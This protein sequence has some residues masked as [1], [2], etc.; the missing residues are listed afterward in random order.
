LNQSLKARVIDLALRGGDGGMLL[1]R[2][3]LRVY[4][5]SIKASV[6]INLITLM[7]ANVE[8]NCEAFYHFS[9]FDGLLFQQEVKSTTLQFL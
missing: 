7:K 6:D 3:D 8:G 2:L 5:R 4:N 9:S 1:N